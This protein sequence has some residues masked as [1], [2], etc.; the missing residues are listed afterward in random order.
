MGAYSAA[1]SGG[2]DSVLSF[3]CKRAR[4]LFVARLPLLRP[5]P[6]AFR[7]RFD[8]HV[9]AFGFALLLE[10]FLTLELLGVLVV[11]FRGISGV[12]TSERTAPGLLAREISVEYFS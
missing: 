8:K 6:V 7:R 12:S 9:T 4:R 5:G 11:R 1:L 2:G 3:F 10:R